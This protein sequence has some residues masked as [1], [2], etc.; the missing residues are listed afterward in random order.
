VIRSHYAAASL[1][2]QED[3]H[4]TGRIHA[5]ALIDRDGKPVVDTYGILWP[6]GPD[7][8]DD[9]RLAKNQAIDSDATYMLEARAVG[10]DADSAGATAD[11]IMAQLIGARLEVEGRRCDPIRLDY[12][13][14]IEYD[15][16]VRPPLAYVDL[17]FVLVSRRG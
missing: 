14:R 3:E 16:R 7:D 12:C 6:T 15:E 17:R 9:Q 5:A 4:L 11:A 2:I 1:K 8:M 10:V 13:D